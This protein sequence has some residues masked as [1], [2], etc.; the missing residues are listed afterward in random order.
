V[1]TIRGD[2]TLDSY[3]MANAHNRAVRNLVHC[4]DSVEEAQREIKVWFTD[5]EIVKYTHINEKMLY[6]IN[7]DGIL[8]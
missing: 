8:E 7:L 4:S 1:G 2:L 3:T 5:D 6:D